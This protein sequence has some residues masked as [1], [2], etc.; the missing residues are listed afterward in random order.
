MERA[1]WDVV[2]DSL[3]GDMPDYSHVLNLVK[4]VRET[5]LELAPTGCKDEISDNINHENLSQ[6]RRV[7]LFFW[8]YGEL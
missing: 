3:R 5:L 6:V 4:E 2:A 7:Q 8:T 1:Y